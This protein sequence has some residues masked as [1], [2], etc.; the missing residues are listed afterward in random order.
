MFVHLNGIG[1]EAM[2]DMGATHNCLA[3]SVTTRLDLRV[4]SYA[5]VTIP[6]NAADQWVDGIV[7]AIL[8][9]IGAWSKQCEMMMM[10][11]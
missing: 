9:H 11:L 5:N 6:L 10:Y 4:E 3:S 2:V 1:V 8:I 7:W